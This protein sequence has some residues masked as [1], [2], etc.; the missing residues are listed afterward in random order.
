MLKESQIDIYVAR[1]GVYCIYC[2]SDHIK[3]TTAGAW[4]D[5][6]VERETNCE[7]CKKSWVELY[8]LAEVREING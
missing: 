6:S 5:D 1:G 2:G 3:W 8:R 7:A 4:D